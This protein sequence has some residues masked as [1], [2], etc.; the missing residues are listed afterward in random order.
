MLMSA[1]EIWV[2]GCFWLA[3]VYS[4]LLGLLVIVLL[5]LNEVLA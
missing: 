5:W 1:T 4:T 3:L 2:L